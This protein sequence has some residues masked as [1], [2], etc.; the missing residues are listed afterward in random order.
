MTCAKLNQGKNCNQRK[1]NL[2]HINLIYYNLLNSHSQVEIWEKNKK[3]MEVYR[4]T[5]AKSIYISKLKHE[6]KEKSVTV[7]LLISES[8]E[9]TKFGVVTGSANPATPIIPSIYATNFIVSTKCPQ[10]WFPI[11]YYNIDHD[12]FYFPHQRIYI[13]KFENSLAYIHHINPSLISINESYDC[14][15]NISSSVTRL[16]YG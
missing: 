3:C 10:Q 5:E 13:S 16:R 15:E 7:N 9:V 12:N 8:V 4:S 14:S 11:E 2:L 1:E 6:N